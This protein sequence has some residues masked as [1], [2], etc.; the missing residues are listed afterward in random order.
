MNSQGFKF[1]ENKPWRGIIGY[2]VPI[3]LSSILQ[4]LYNTVDLFVLGAFESQASMASVGSCSFLIGLMVTFAVGLSSGLSVIISSEL[5]KGENDNKACLQNG[6]IIVAFFGII[7]SLFVYFM[8][9]ILIVRLIQLPSIL[10]P[11]AIEYLKICA[12]GVLF[13][14]LYN[15][16]RGVLLGYG[17]SKVSLYFLAISA[18]LNIVLDIVLVKGFD[19]GAA[20]VAWSTVAAQI[21]ALVFSVF[22]LYKR[23]PDIFNVLVSKNWKIEAGS[24]WEVIRVGIPVSFQGIVVNMGYMIIQNTVNSFGSDM[25][26][27]YSVASKLEMYLLI[28]FI[29]F[30]NA[31]S[32]CVGFLLGNERIGTV[33]KIMRQTRIAYI[34]LA[35]TIGSAAFFTAPAWAGLFGL[36]SKASELFISHFRMI[37]FDILIY[38]LYSPVNAFFIGSKK[39]Y[40]LLICSLVEMSGRIITI[41]FLSGAV[42]EAAVWFSEPVPWSF[43]CIMMN[44]IYFCILMRADGKTRL[45]L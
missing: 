27:S 4:Q 37:A 36:N 10:A 40:M 18:A 13:E 29:S 14:F 12:I 7:M 16:F 44:I 25:T 41:N 39:T 23:Y 26:A 17:D 35:V 32:V 1:D 43:V 9:P 38:S 15:Y 34:L 11:A 22:Y 20:G 21:A 24:M 30:T 3:L 2:A 8:G 45:N 42:G 19:M 31:L 6:L 33:K 5:G 28:P